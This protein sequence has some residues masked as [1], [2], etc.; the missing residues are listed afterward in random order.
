M[1]PQDPKDVTRDTTRDLSRLV[2]ELAALKADA[3][4]WLT[5]PEYA[6]LQYR[7]EAA[8]AATEAAL[9]EARRRVRLNERRNAYERGRNFEKSSRRKINAE[10]IP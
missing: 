1:G 8:H 9:V 10:G 2:G 3:T 5:D 7:L 4:H 6:A